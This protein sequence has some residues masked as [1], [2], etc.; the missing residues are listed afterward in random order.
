MS[1]L[2][3]V[4]VSESVFGCVGLE[5]LFSNDVKGWGWDGTLRSVSAFLEL[6]I[7]FELLEVIW[8][9]GVVC[10]VDLLGVGCRCSRDCIFFSVTSV[11]SEFGGV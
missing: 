2:F 6:E 10:G 9:G 4:T 3:F 7:L 8:V 1:V 11:L 5:F